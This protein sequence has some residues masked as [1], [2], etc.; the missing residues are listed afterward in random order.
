MYDEYDDGSFDLIPRNA[1]AWGNSGQQNQQPQP[2]VRDHRTQGGPQPMPQPLPGGTI[3]VSARP[4]PGSPA[5]M[6]A[7]GYPPGAYPTPGGY[8]G[9]PGPWP[10]PQSPYGQYSMVPQSPPCA[11][12]FGAF[13]QP[14]NVS[15]VLRLVG[16][17]VD[18]IGAGVAAIMPIPDAPQIVGQQPV[19]DENMK[20]YQEGLAQH[21]KTDERIR[22][23]CK[24]VRE[25]LAVKL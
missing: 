14:V 24:I 3:V 21:A 13:G 11:P 1:S 10:Y 18:C 25:A 16:V 12:P 17:A 15:K 7:A 4:V 19:D 5:A 22:T 8:P 20:R 2:V 9:Y 6:A 23:F